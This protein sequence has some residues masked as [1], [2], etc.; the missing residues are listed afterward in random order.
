MSGLVLCRHT[1]H[2]GM[3]TRNA[4]SH[5]DH[6]HTNERTG[7]AYPSI[8]GER[9]DP[10]TK[11]L[12]SIAV[13]IRE[14][15]TSAQTL[16]REAE[17]RPAKKNAQK[18]RLRRVKGTV[19]SL[20]DHWDS[21]REGIRSYVGECTSS[22]NR[23]VEWIQGWNQLTYRTRFDEVVQQAMC[24]FACRRQCDFQCRVT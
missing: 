19:G 24:A 5:D 3:E 13:H 4:H 14:I 20:R 11:L 10:G 23:P 7:S 16:F 22:G 8:V 21:A 9:D 6:E 12:D 18:R 15:I 17:N 1:Q 2:H